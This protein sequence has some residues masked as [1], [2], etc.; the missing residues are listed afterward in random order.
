MIRSCKKNLSIKAPPSCL[1]VKNQK[2]ES[3][4]VLLLKESSPKPERLGSQRKVRALLRNP[5][6]KKPLQNHPLKLRGILLKSAKN[7]KKRRELKEYANLNWIMKALLPS[8]SRIK[9]LRWVKIRRW[10]IRRAIKY[11]WLKT[12]TH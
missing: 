1:R 8:P 12:I 4:S 2:L 11:L 7:H 5:R 6:S 9:T 10:W 3:L